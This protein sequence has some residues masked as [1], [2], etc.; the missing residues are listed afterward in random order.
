MDVAYVLLLFFSWCIA[1]FLLQVESPEKAGFAV[2]DTMDV[3]YIGKNEKG[4]M[5]LSRRAV[6]MRDSP[7]SAT[8]AGGVVLPDGAAAAEP[9]KIVS[10]PLEEGKVYKDCT[11]ISVHAFGVFV[12]VAAGQE[13]LVHVS[14]LEPKR[15]R[16]IHRYDP[17][18]VLLH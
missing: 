2:G 18:C 12:E 11:I 3:K 15:V 8:G 1:S 6:L 9:V 7:S 14:E 5:R 4:Q 10:P 13:G 16:Q 17:L